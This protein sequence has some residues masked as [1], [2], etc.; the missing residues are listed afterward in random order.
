MI[1]SMAFFW[2][3]LPSPISLPVGQAR[4]AAALPDEPDEPG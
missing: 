1:S 4:E 2:A 3:E